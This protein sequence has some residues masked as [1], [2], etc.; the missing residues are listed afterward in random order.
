MKLGLIT[1]V[2]TRLPKSH[3]TWEDT[4]GIS[5]VARMAIAAEQLTALRELFPVTGVSHA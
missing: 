2:L 4:A 5:E 3:A 1:P